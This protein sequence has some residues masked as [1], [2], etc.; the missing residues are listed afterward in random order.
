MLSNVLSPD[1]G[2]NIGEHPSVVRLLKGV[3]NTRHP[4]KQLLTEWDLELVLKVLKGTPF[5]P[6]RK[7]L[8]K[9]VTYKFV[10]L[11]AIVTARRVSDLSHLALGKFCRIRNS[12]IT[13]LPTNL[14]KADDPSHFLKNIVIVSFPDKLLVVRRLMKFYFKATEKL[15]LSSKDPRS[16]LRCL[17][18]P[19]NPNFFSNYI[20]VDLFSY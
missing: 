3:F 16:L 20:K 12:T 7:A 10:L 8:L 13:F 4:K 2:K 19:Y 1:D 15:R 5:E 6:I 17:S 9:L 14:T 18:N 11:L